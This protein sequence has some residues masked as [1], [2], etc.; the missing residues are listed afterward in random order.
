MSS[1]DFSNIRTH[2]DVSTPGQQDRC[3]SHIPR[4]RSLEANLATFLRAIGS[5]RHRRKSCLDLRTQNSKPTHRHAWTPGP[6]PPPSIMMSQPQ[7]PPAPL[8]WPFPL[9]LLRRLLGR[10][11]VLSVTTQRILSRDYC[12]LPERRNLT[13]SETLDQCSSFQSL[14]ET[15]AY[16]SLEG[17]ATVL[18][19]AHRY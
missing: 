10:R 15:C 5:Q 7:W 8:L 12:V 3:C 13:S 14:I 17:N 6:Q 11:D 18:C 9:K 1:L 2:T 16:P 19:V 4:I